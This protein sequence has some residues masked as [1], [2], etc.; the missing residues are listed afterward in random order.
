MPPLKSAEPY[1]HNSE[2]ALF[3]IRDQ[4]PKTVERDESVDDVS[5]LLSLASSADSGGLDGRAHSLS[6]AMPGILEE[7]YVMLE[8]SLDFHGVE[9]DCKDDFQGGHGIG[10]GWKD[11]SSSPKRRRLDGSDGGSDGYDS[12]VDSEL[13]QDEG[14]EDVE[15]ERDEVEI[16]EAYITKDNDTLR[17]IATLLNIDVEVLLN[18]NHER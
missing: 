9:F 10:K 1:P 8:N 5:R 11:A 12:S 13:E 15:E 3:K 2:Q 17:I 6:L 16:P 7:G 14:V 18:L 4:R